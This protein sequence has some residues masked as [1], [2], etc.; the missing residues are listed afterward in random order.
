MYPFFFDWTF[1]LLIPALILAGWAQW[2]VRSAYSEFSKVPTRGRQ[3]GG[4][5]AA[6]I[7]A[8]N[9][10]DQVRVEPVSGTLTDHYD[11]RTRVVRLSEDNY[12]GRSVAAVSIAAHEVG[13]ALQHGQSYG[14]LVLR[15][16]MYPVVSFSST[17]AFPLF[18]IGF[19]ASIPS[20][21]MTLSC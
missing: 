14:P 8:G 4:E 2:K 19:I 1:L 13:H 3:S 21:M 17:L 16:A 15:T 12:R 10:L 5:V 6:R 18:F 7:L 20:L 11:P 9:N